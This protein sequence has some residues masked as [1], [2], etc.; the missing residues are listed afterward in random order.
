MAKYTFVVL[1]NPTSGKEAEYN[2][3]YNEIHIPDVLNV[4]GM[5]AAQRFKL[6]DTQMGGAPAHRYLAIYEIETDN[7]QATF[8]DLKS[9]SG[10]EDMVLTDAI[11]L[12]GVMAA[13]FTPA[14]ERVWA[15]D[16]QRPRRAK[17][18]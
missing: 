14:A 2:K 11:D 18:A 17:A 9:R 10:T 3:W 12:K 4:Q 6:A 5:V 16:V 13:V 15:K 8:D 7:L 1:T